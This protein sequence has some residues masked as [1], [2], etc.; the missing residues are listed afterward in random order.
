MTIVIQEMSRTVVSAVNRGTFKIADWTV[1]PKKGVLKKFLDQHP[2][3]RDSLARLSERHQERLRVKQG[4]Q[5]QNPDEETPA[6]GPAGGNDD[7]ADNAEKEETLEKLAQEETDHDLA[8]QLAIAI[9][10]VAQDLRADPPKRYGYE[11]WVHFTKLIRFSKTSKEGVE[12]IEEEE[13]LVEWDWIGE[14]SPML[15]DITESQWLLD[16]LCE[17]LNR[18]TR[19]QAQIVRRPPP[20]TPS[21]TSQVL[22][23]G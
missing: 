4:F 11:Q 9:K 10:S 5:V 16:R 23:P 18:Y 3:L 19:R 1:M 13:G 6:A 8:R 14:D 20:Y 7:T 15:A 21:A 12:Q 2:R 22:S 17:S